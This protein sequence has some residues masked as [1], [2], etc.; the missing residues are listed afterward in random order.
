MK[1]DASTNNLTKYLSEIGKY[2]ILNGNEFSELFKKYREGST[3][4]KNKLINHNLRLV[5]SLAMK[6]P[7]RDENI[8]DFISE[9]NLGLIR[10]I[11]KFDPDLGFAFSTYAERWI[12]YRIE[13]FISGNS[14]IVHVPTN[15]LKAARKVEKAQRTLGPSGTEMD[16]IAKIIGESA[17]HVSQMLLLNQNPIQIDAPV[18]DDSS[19]TVGDS[20]AQDSKGLFDEVNDTKTGQ[21]LMSNVVKLPEKQKEAIINYFGFGHSQEMSMVDIGRDMGLS[22]Q[23]IRQ[24][25]EDGTVNL[26]DMAQKEHVSF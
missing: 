26:R 1:S 9:G 22:R 2:E 15:V 17:E 14:K 23:R 18:N 12:R 24:L 20:L 4:A 3:F 25:I 21:W 6:Y 8:D 7:Y 16:D 19:I 5:V 13:H 11:E 10:A